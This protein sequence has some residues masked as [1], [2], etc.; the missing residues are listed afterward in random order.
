MA[1]TTNAEIYIALRNHLASYSGLPFVAY[2]M[3]GGE[4]PIG[5][6]GLPELY[7]IVQDLR[8]PV[9]SRFIGADDPDE[10]S[11]SFQVHVMA[12]GQETHP[13]IMYQVGLIANH[14]PKLMTL[15]VGGSRLQV[16]GTPYLATEPYQDGVYYRA[17]VLV[18]WRLSV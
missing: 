17:P 16:T 2:P 3:I 10:Y 14:F 4:P 8:L 5:A 7:W 6:N 13:Q 18:P 15:S 9:S 12:S 1:A 11:G